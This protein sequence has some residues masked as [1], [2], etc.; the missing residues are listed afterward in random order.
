MLL[1]L[2]SISVM[3]LFLTATPAPLV[4]HF[5][6]VGYGDAIVLHL[7]EGGTVLVDGGAP[8][9]GPQVA[10]VLRDKGVQELDYLVVTHFHK[11]HVGGLDPILKEFMPIYNRQKQTDKLGRILIPLLP[12][13]VEP[14]IELLKA[15]IERRPYSIVSRG[16]TILASPSVRID[17]LHPKALTGDANEDS[18]AVRVTHGRITILLGGDVGLEAQKELLHEYGSRLKADVIKIPHHGGETEESFIEAVRPQVAILTVG[19]NSYGLPK[20][21]V[22]K[23]YQKI[24][25]HIHRT[26]EVGAI[27]IITDGRSFT[28]HSERLP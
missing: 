6:D 13:G 4:I 11:D 24:G 18:L 8:E 16:R 12:S 20:P 23:M 1:T 7:P 19:P 25:A 2:L 26:D 5:L 27:T 17:V 3:G 9:R 22:L 10:T 28:V 14:E 15:E 21:E